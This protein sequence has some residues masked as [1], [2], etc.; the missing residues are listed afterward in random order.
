MVTGFGKKIEEWTRIEFYYNLY[1]CH[2]YKTV[3]LNV[4]V[5]LSFQDG[6]TCSNFSG[7]TKLKK[8]KLWKLNLFLSYRY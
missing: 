8:K 4:L 1:Y 6:R 3:D 5:G 7:T 2:G